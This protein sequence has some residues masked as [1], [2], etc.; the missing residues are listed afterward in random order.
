MKKSLALVLLFASAAAQAQ[1]GLNYTD[2]YATV[3]TTPVM[4][5][6]PNGARKTLFVEN[7]T[8]APNNIGYCVAAIGMSCT[9]VIDSGPPST[10]V[11]SP[12]VAD[13]WPYGN[14]P[15]GALYCIASGASSPVNVRSGQ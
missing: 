11:L 14:A 6:P 10:S 5:A 13:F 2:Y 7:P 12:G 4:C 1:S 15:A 8:G 3:G 9:P